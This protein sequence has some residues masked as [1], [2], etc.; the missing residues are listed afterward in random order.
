MIVLLGAAIFSTTYLNPLE[1]RN[2]Y[3]SSSVFYRGLLAPS[4]TSTET[5]MTFH[6]I[7]KL[8]LTH[9]GQITMLLRIVEYFKCDTHNNRSTICW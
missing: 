5:Y 4:P 6:I 3:R 2:V 7:R 1:E 8:F 9:D